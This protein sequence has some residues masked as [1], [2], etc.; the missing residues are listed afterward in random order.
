MSD[1]LRPV[2][3]LGCYGSPLGQLAA[4]SH[5]ELGAESLYT[6]AAIAQMK[7]SALDLFMSIEEAHLEATTTINALFEQTD[8]N[9]FSQDPFT[10]DKQHRPDVMLW[11]A[12]RRKS[13]DLGWFALRN[14][15]RQAQLAE[16]LNEDLPVL[17]ENTESMANR[18]HLLGLLPANALGQ[19]AGVRKQYGPVHAMDPF[20]AGALGANGYCNG[21]RIA[22]RNLY[23]NPQD[24]TGIGQRLTATALHES[25]HATGIPNGRGF[26]NGISTDTPVRILEEVTASHLTEVAHSKGWPM[27]ETIAPDLR[28]GSL[29]Q[30]YYTERYI[31]SQLYI[32]AELLVTAYFSE[33]DS[34]ERAQ[35][36]DLVTKKF[37]L[38][39]GQ[40]FFEFCNDY[41]TAESG[42]ALRRV[43]ARTIEQLILRDIQEPTLETIEDLEPSND[44]VVVREVPRPE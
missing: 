37:E 1:V 12:T 9:A 11:L 36:E 34:K 33:K 30:G 31:A 16:R 42:R 26:M 23:D 10:E 40:P 41:E 43:L 22:L 2:E 28:E 3:I 24:M 18:L 5:R 35:L 15:E 39:T 4:T 13:K 17:D 29:V 44:L 8:R 14:T 27:P 19:I 21:T 7:G 25:L 20:E 38:R 32:P 6:A